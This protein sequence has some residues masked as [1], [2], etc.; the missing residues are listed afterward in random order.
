MRKPSG[1]GSKPHRPRAWRHAR[2]HSAVEE[3]RR[4]AGGGRKNL[5]ENLAAG[6][7]GW[8]QV[9]Q[10]CTFAATG[11]MDSLRRLLG[12][13]RLSTKARINRGYSVLVSPSWV[14]GVQVEGT[15]SDMIFHAIR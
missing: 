11:H 3:A 12:R 15:L 6:R 13:Q 1:A 14:A 9:R 4:I 8:H 7:A 2:A 10:G 5:A